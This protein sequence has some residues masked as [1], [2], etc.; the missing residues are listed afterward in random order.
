MAL[1][2]YLWRPVGLPLAIS[3]SVA[4]ATSWSAYLWQPSWNAVHSERQKRAFGLDLVR[5][6]AIGLVIASH[7]G[8][9]LPAWRGIPPHYA[10]ALLGVVGVDLFFTL[11]GFL[12]GRLLIDIVRIAPS[13][14]NLRIFLIRRWMR[15]L[16]LYVVW[17]CVSIVFFPPADHGLRYFLE[18]LTFTQNLAWPMPP[19]NWFGVSWSL[20]IEEWFYLVFG[21]CAIGIA[22]RRRTPQAMLI[23]LALF[24][25]VPAVLRWMVPD[26]ANW[27]N[28]IVGVVVM[29]LDSIGYG[30][31]L[32]WVRFAYPRLFG[33][34]LI[35]GIIGIVLA[36]SAYGC[37]TAAGWIFPFHIYR[38]FVLTVTDLGFLLCIIGATAWTAAHGWIARIVAK[39]SDISYG[40][41]IMHLTILL[42]GGSWLV[43]GYWPAIGAIVIVT[44]ALAM[45][46]WHCFEA[47]ILRLRPQQT[48]TTS[49]FDKADGDA[50]RARDASDFT[51]LTPAQ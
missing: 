4:L 37:M 23:P 43:Y 50:S 41:Y 18:Y 3:W 45:F 27:G 14:S 15:T 13:F 51:A 30:V 6:V 40:L 21:V 28:D 19:S 2:S 39:I 34:P 5:A 17:L 47:P 9:L 46:S 7:Y 49:G 8:I 11:S 48:F 29:R 31:V 26:T 35:C 24:C 22:M 33:H 36:V 42:A 1:N 10:V 20:T 38:T 16:P 32:A 12:I 25:I 44:I